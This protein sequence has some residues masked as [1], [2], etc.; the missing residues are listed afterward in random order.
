MYSK[1]VSSS[2]EQVLKIKGERYKV[3]EIV[4]RNVFAFRFVMNKINEHPEHFNKYI[5]PITSNSMED[6]VAQIKKFLLK[7]KE[8]NDYL[9]EL[10]N[11]KNN[12]IGIPVDW[13]IEGEYG[14]YISKRGACRNGI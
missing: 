1:L 5:W 3:C 8:R 12:T 13:L 6:M 4:D 9:V 2:I 10:Y 11:F 14:R 7:S